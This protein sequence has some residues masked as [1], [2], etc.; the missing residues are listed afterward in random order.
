MMTLGELTRIR[1]H[2]EQIGINCPRVGGCDRDRPAEMCLSCHSRE[3]AVTER[4]RL[5][6]E[7]ERLRQMFMASR[8]RRYGD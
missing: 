1:I 3:V 7:V 4:E 2:V 6:A 8:P 5:L